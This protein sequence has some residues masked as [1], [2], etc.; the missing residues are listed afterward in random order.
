ME[1]MSWELLG[2]MWSGSSKWACSD[3]EAEEA[4]E[5]IRQAWR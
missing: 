4:A 5:S 3:E 1:P 2:E